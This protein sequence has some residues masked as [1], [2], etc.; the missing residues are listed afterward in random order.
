MNFCFLLTKLRLIFFFKICKT[1]Q[2]TN[3]LFT[4]LLNSV[5]YTEILFDITESAAAYKYTGN[6][7]DPKK[8][9]SGDASCFDK[10]CEH[11]TIKKI[12]LTTTR[13]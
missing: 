1:S 10:I 2:V 9:S 11:H 7:H 8:N 4:Y 13:I 12:Q 5:D 6:I 3:R